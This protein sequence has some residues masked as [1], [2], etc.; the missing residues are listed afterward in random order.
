MYASSLSNGQVN[1]LR[2]L[3]ELDRESSVNTMRLST[4]LRINQAADNPGLWA[5][6]SAMRSQVEGTR[7]IADGM[8]MSIGAVDVAGAATQRLLPLLTRFRDLLVAG[9]NDAAGRPA[10]QAQMDDL[11]GQMLSVIQN[12]SYNGVN[13]LFHRNGQSYTFNMVTG[14]SA[15][16]GNLQ[17]VTETLD[18]TALTLVDEVNTNGILSRQYSMGGNTF[19]KMF[20]NYGGNAFRIGLYQNATTVATGFAYDTA[21]WATNQMINQVTDVAATFGSLKGRLESQQS[22]LTQLADIQT[23]SIGRMVDADM[24]EETTRARAIEARTRLAYEGMSIA[25]SRQRLVLQLF[26]PATGTQA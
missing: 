17:S 25:N 4:G 3:R 10:M 14:Q 23:R 9:K 16:D 6:A 18:T 13:L 7:T 15:Q 24:A 21:L 22:F 26:Q 1:T 11:K 5:I 8:Q 19:R 12:A 20:D 2:M